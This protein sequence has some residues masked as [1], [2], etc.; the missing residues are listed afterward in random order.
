MFRL[1]LLSSLVFTIT[2]MLVSVNPFPGCSPWASASA[3][4]LY[5]P[6]TAHINP[7]EF[8]AFWD[9]FFTEKLTTSHVPGA[10][11]VVVQNGEVLLAKGYGVSDIDKQGAVSPDTTLF[12]LG[13]VAK[14]MTAT[15]V[16]QLVEQGSLDLQADVNDYLSDFQITDTY[17]QPITLF[18]LLT[19]T[20]GLEQHGIDTA[21]Q[22]TDDYLSLSTYLQKQPPQRLMPPGEVIIYSSVG[23]AIAGQVVEDVT[24]EPFAEYIR[25]HIFNLL[26]MTRTSFIVPP[27]YPTVNTAIGY[28]Y[29]NGEYIPYLDRYYSLVAPG[30]DFISTGLDMAN[31][32]LAYLK[33]GRLGNTQL[34][35]P[36]TVQYIQSQQVTHHPKIRGRAIG[37]SEWIESGQRAIFH[38]GSAPG[39]LSRVFLVPEHDLGFFVAYNNGNALNLKQEVT[40]ELLNIYFPD[41]DIETEPFPTEP[42]LNPP[43]Y[44]FAGYY[45]DYELSPS[46]IGKLSTLLNQIPI[47][48]IDDQ[49]IQIGSKEYIRFHSTLFQTIAGTSYAAFREDNGEVIHLLLGTSAFEKVSWYESKP[50]QIGL[51]AVF[52]LT[53][54][55]ATFLMI[56]TSLKKQPS[57]S[58]RWFASLTCGLNLAFLIGLSLNFMSILNDPWSLI[59]GLTPMLKFLLI[60]PLV[61]SVLAL[62]MSVLTFLVWK[63]KYWSLIGRLLYTWVTITALGFI[64][65]LHYWNLLDWL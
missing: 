53:F 64:P 9:D 26:R 35:K 29:Q 63:Y 36:E 27:D 43:I 58:F 34:L 25:Q 50:F 41:S 28:R 12:H 40:S 54:L 32:M 38:D 59:Y 48:V 51:I 23:I 10:V 18:H 21:A 20:S 44:E 46:N 31:F 3:V 33:D 1:K 60:I 47:K 19:H 7:S 42:N 11:F 65:F 2:I 4:E 45:R 62:C 24:G 6:V 56:F 14:L 15:A 55:I 49:S 8:E 16:M 22:G 39:F 61:T 5:G 37:F 17:P 30:G 52:V 57:R 13:S